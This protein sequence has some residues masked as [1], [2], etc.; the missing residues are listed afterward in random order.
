[1]A[2]WRLGAFLIDS[3]EMK[4]TLVRAGRIDQKSSADGAK[5]QTCM[6]RAFQ[7]LPTE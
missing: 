1:M 5:R 4:V 6:E 3:R 2:W 7:R